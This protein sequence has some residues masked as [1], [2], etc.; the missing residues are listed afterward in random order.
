MYGG[1]GWRKEK[2]WVVGKYGEREWSEGGRG[3][4]RGAPSH[5]SNMKIKIS[6][7]HVFDAKIMSL[8]GHVTK[9]NVSF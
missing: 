2:C 5:M 8:C 9:L 7:S 1:G 6:I 3:E 4:R